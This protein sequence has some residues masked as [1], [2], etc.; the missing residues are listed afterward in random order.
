MCDIHDKNFYVK[1]LIL[2]KNDWLHPENVSETENKIPP[3]CRH[4]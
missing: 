1:G 4:F 3:F 2:A